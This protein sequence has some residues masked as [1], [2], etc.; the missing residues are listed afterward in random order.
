MKKSFCQDPFLFLRF[1]PFM[2]LSRSPYAGNALLDQWPF[3][4]EL[5]WKLFGGPTSRS[6]WL[7]SVPTILQFRRGLQCLFDHVVSEVDD[8]RNE[9]V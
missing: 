3:T 9:I 4:L 7:H 1:Q 6:G 2:I 8:A 5:H